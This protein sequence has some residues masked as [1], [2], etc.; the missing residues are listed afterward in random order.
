MFEIPSIRQKKFNKYVPQALFQK[1]KWEGVF[2]F[3]HF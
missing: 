3:I 2:I 1:M